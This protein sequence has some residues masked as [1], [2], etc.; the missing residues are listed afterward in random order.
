MEPTRLSNQAGVRSCWRAELREITP[1]SRSPRPKDGLVMAKR[2]SNCL[3]LRSSP[4]LSKA[5]GVKP[6]AL[7]AP[8]CP[9]EPCP[10]KNQFLRYLVALFTAVAYLTLSQLLESIGGARSLT[11]WVLS[12]STATV[13]QDRPPLRTVKRSGPGG[14]SMG[15]VTSMEPHG[16]PPAYA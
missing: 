15:S 11:L 13:N 9:A 4:V 12:W 16:S 14:G 5:Q 2:G 6:A 3:L 1:K 10:F 8:C 7:L